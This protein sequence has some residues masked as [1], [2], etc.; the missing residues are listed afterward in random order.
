VARARPWGLRLASPRGLIAAFLVA[1]AIAAPASLPAYG[2]EVFVLAL[3]YAILAIGMDLLMGYTGLDSLGQAA[4]FGT[5]TY[6]VGILT[7]K[8]G[9]GWPVSAVVGLGLS[10]LLAAVFGLLAVR[11]RGLYFLL[12]TLALGEV[13]WGG[14]QRWGSLTGG[15]NGLSGVPMPTPRLADPVVFAYRVLAVF[16]LV[17]AGARLVATSPFG[18]GLQGCR[19]NEVRLRS[20]GFRPFWLKW[21]VFVIAGFAA[22]LAGVLNVT[23]NSFVSPSDLSLQLSFAVMLMV[24][25]GGA[26]NLVGAVLGA[27]VITAL[28]YELSNYIQD[29]WLMVLGL[30]YM[31][32]TLFLP[33]GIVGATRRLRRADGPQAVP[34]PG[35]S[36]EGHG[37]DARATGPRP[38]PRNSQDAV[39]TLREVGKS[40]GGIRVLDQVTLEFWPGERAAVIGPNGAGKT[41]LFNLITGLEHPSSGRIV[42]LGTDVTGQPSYTRPALGLARTFQVTRLFPPLSVLDNVTLG[43]LGWSS[44]GH[45]YTLWRRTRKIAGL[46]ARARDVL[47]AVGLDEMR[48]IP[49]RQ[50]SYGHRKQLDIAI[51]L[52]SEPRVLLLDEPT[53]GLSQGE[54]T[55]TMELL[56]RLPN[57]ITVVVIEHNLDFVFDLTDRLIV[58]DHG[59]VMLDGP[60]ETVRE[61]EDVRRIYF[62]VTA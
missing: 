45:Q 28:Q 52:A 26:G 3:I 42:V 21:L 7:V 13:L 33:Q 36:E 17:L 2:L 14:A 51:A 55:R 43:L 8:A 30:V 50:L 35:A 6:S 58:L 9:V 57:E 31:G 5:A 61:S 16:A 19:D 12:I 29:W 60:Q 15:Y 54:A 44:R 24:I 56:G 32:A 10:T 49:V 59:R 18:L 11:L 4:F 23:Y 40:F 25:V 46:E 41:T 39:L 53:A 38:H 48:F 62:G 47:A 22:G 34:D 20:L 27:F 1:L 37:P